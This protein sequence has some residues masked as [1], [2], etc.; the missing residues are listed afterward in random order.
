MITTNQKIKELIKELNPLEDFF[1]ID[2]LK[3]KLEEKT[4]TYL[5]K[6][7][8]SEKE[9]YHANTGVTKILWRVLR[10]NQDSRRLKIDNILERTDCRNC[11]FSLSKSSHVGYGDRVSLVTYKTRQEESERCDR[12]ENKRD[13]FYNESEL[14]YNADR[15]AESKVKEQEEL[16]KC[17]ALI[18][19]LKT[20]LK[21]YAT[22]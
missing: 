7:E 20:K 15:Y 22:S 19:K 10:E 13:I 14:Y 11:K 4:Q 3:I 21:D 1:L 8:V 2:L 5:K 12:C 6:Y 17:K 9:Y 16:I 18:N